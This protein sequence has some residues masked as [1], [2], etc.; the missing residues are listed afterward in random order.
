MI[1]NENRNARIL[2]KIERQ[3]I[4]NSQ[5]VQL[6]EDEKRLYHEKEAELQAMENKLKE[7]TSDINRKLSDLDDIKK[8]ISIYLEKTGVCSVINICMTVYCLIIS[9]KS[10]ISGRK[11]NR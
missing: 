1:K 5:K 2:L 9:G 8:K 10:N 7:S 11:T 4:I 3:K 6:L